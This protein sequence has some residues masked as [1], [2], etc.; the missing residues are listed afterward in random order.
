MTKDNRK[1]AR[2]LARE[3]FSVGQKERPVT[4]LALK[5][6]DWAGGKER[7][8]GGL[9]EDALRDVLQRALDKYEPRE[10]LKP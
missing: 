4:R 5:S 6:G 3:V 7:D 2:Y 9:C 1:F 10:P 8:E